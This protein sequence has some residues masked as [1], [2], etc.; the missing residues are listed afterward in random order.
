MCSIC[1]S[2]ILKREKKVFDPIK[3][4]SISTSYPNNKSGTTRK[5][6]LNLLKNDCSFFSRLYKS[7]QT[8]SVEKM[9][10][11]GGALVYMLRPGTNKT[12]DEYAPIVFLPYIC[13]QLELVNRID[14]VWDVFIADSLNDALREKSER[15][16][17]RRVSA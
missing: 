9:V 13:R 10:V 8:P 15:G 6:K 12:F 7:C 17:R 3:K 11:Y 4:N 2:E 5:S 14:I 1:G 16:I